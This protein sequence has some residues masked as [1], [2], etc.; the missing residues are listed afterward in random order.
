M[1]LTK[2]THWLEANYLTLNV[3]KT[4]LQVY[5]MRKSY[6]TINIY[7]NGAAIEGVR[8]IK[9]LGV[10]LDTDLKFTSH[11]NSISNIISRNIGTIA[12]AKYYL[13]KQQL[14][15]LYNS[16]IF[17]YI[18]YCCFIWG[19][20]YDEHLLKLKILQKRCMRLIEGVFPPQSATPIFKKYNVLKIKDVAHLQILLIMHNYLQQNLPPAIEDLLHQCPE[21]I[22]PT[23][24]QNHFQTNFSR[25]NY[26]LFTF[27]CL[28]PKLWNDLI[29]NNFPISEIPHSKMTF[30]SYLKSVFLDTY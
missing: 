24:R 14:L 25:K 16:L 26:R 11:I 1:A 13:T 20:N 29:S 8:T 15:Q 23:R 6:E 10:L 18:N 21:P 3:S 30:K 17:P 5:T 12:R 19:S 2:I 7:I 9:Y 22:H 4:F 27:A 28:G